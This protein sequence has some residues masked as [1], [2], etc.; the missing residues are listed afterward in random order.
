MCPANLTETQWMK[1]WR[2]FY[3]A[4]WY[5]EMRKG[6][7]ELIQE[8]GAYQNESYLLSGFKS[9]SEVWGGIDSFRIDKYMFLVR[10]MLRNVLKQQVIALL[11]GKLLFADNPF[12]SELKKNF[13]SK[14]NTDNSS[15]EA[16]VID[17]IVSVTSNSVGLFLHICDI[18]IDELQKVLLELVKDD[19][20]VKIN[21]YYQMLFPFARRL[22]TIQDERLRKSIRANIFN[23]LL[24]EVIIVKSISVQVDTLEKFLEPLT[25]VSAHT[26]SGKNRNCLYSIA[27][28]VRSKVASLKCPE[29]VGVQLKRKAI[30]IDRK[31]KKIKYEIGTSVPF[32]RSLVPLPLM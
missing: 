23:K 27:D 32:V 1:M 29:K 21:M 4:I 10:H 18:Y 6:G 12:L 30:G 5:S 7:E 13:E 22:A 14:K 31:T 9:L 3:Y 2:G 11:E 24:D 15:V 26:E 20:V 16:I 8:M 25:Q 28:K 17:Y 19:D